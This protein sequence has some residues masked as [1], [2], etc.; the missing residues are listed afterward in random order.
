MTL[1]LCPPLLPSLDAY[2]IVSHLE[3]ITKS[4]HIDLRPPRGDH[5]N[6]DVPPPRGGCLDSLVSSSRGGR[7][8]SLAPPPKLGDSSTGASAP[9]VRG[10]NPDSGAAQGKRW[11]GLG[12]DNVVVNHLGKSLVAQEF[13][14]GLIRDGK[15]AS[16]DAVQKP[17]KDEEELHPHGDETVAFAA[18]FNAM[19]CFPCVKFVTEVLRLNDLELPQ[20]T[21]NTIA[22]LAV[23]EWVMRSEAAWGMPPSLPISTMPSPNLRS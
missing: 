3:E 9:P 7:C 5:R 21:A 11:K 19:L 15:V 1:E 20:L 8:D 23:F 6:L 2:D 22:R 17:L 14:E 4:D 18:Y 16:L 10:Y 12:K 13:L